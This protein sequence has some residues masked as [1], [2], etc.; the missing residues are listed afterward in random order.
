MKKVI[1]N[2]VAGLF[3]LI[4]GIMAFLLGYTGWIESQD[5]SQFSFMAGLI[6]GWCGAALFFSLLITGMD[7]IKSRKSNE[8]NK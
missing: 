6:S 3:L 5:G 2:V 7:Y 4:L 1:M 8:I